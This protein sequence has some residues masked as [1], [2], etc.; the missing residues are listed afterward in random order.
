MPE[1]CTMYNIKTLNAPTV[2]K[3]VYRPHATPNFKQTVS[4]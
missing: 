2:E 1:H 3:D 4:K